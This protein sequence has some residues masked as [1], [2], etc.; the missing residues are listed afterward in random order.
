MFA[1]ASVSRMPSLPF[2]LAA[3]SER[4]PV[5]SPD[6][7]P[8]LDL[9][10]VNIII[11]PELNLPDTMSALCRALESMASANGWDWKGCV[12]DMPTPDSMTEV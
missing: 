5:G 9:K 6:L 7:I 8:Q 10:K 4:Q 12:G 3:L 11:D 2:V 1:N